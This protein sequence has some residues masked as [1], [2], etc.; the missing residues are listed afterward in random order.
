MK[1]LT[2]LLVIA[3]V[4]CYACTERPKMIYIP[5]TPDY[6]KGKDFLDQGKNDSAFHY[7]YKATTSS[8]SSIYIALA[9]HQM[10]YIQYTAGDYYGSQENLSQ[11]LLHLNKPTPHDTSC[12]FSNYQ[13]LGK[14][15]LNLKNYDMAIEYTDLSLKFAANDTSAQIIALNIKAVIYQKKRQYDKAIEIY[16]SIIDSSKS[17]KKEYARILS[18]LSTAR[19]LQNPEYKAAPG[20]QLA[21][22]LRKEIKDTLGLNAS[23]AHLSD[24]YANSHPDS[25]LTY[26]HKMYVITQQLNSPDDELEALQKLIMLGPLNTLKQYFTRYQYLDD[27]IKTARNT[28][29]N[30]FALIRYES[31]KSK[32]DNL[33]LQKDNADKEVQL[34][35]QS[36]LLYGTAAGS[37]ILFILAIR[38]YR[39][40]KQKML[41]ESRNAIREHKLQT[42]QKVHDVV[43]NGIYRIMTTV[44]HQDIIEKEPLL[45]NLEVLYE[46]SR[47]ISYEKPAIVRHDFN[48][49]IPGL[50]SS[51]SSPDTKILI[52][53]DHKDLWTR[54][55]DPVKKEL[56]QVLQELMVNMKKHSNARTVVIRFEQQDDLVKIQYTDDGV[57]LPPNFRYGNGLTNTGNRIESMGGR[58]NFDRNTEKGLKIE[59]LLPTATIQV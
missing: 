6:Q 19:W 27:S 35:K 11:S 25:A 37:I 58:I 34:I 50:L 29:K 21:L 52:V 16:Q 38:W 10:G 13:L 12:L 51:F 26:A 45:D 53:G 20:L 30:Q 4:S 46:Q 41:Q 7:F 17:D 42:S 33:L 18:N 49:N 55:K 32:S 22:Q 23:Y 28:A 5:Q 24:Y 43:A 9:Y 40:R 14:T 8:K 36:I 3:A 1:T 44:E 48:D 57:G 47:D 39:K 15:N 59:I 54:I 2:Q 31:E 56:E